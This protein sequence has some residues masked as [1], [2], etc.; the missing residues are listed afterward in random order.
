[1]PPAGSVP[2]D[3]QRRYA[4]DDDRTPRRRG[5]SRDGDEAPRRYSGP[6]AATPETRTIAQ[7]SGER[8]TVTITGRPGERPQPPSG[9]RPVVRHARAPRRSPD[10]VAM[11]AVLLGLA[12][13]L[14]AATS[15]HAAVLHAVASM[16]H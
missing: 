7:R 11:W 8:R 12:L 14:G 15:S 4:Q 10:R 9:A 13:A 2:R 16:A 1:M 6:V 5:P 3:G